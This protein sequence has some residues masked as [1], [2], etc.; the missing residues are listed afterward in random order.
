VH[1]WVVEQTVALLLDQPSEYSRVRPM[2]SYPP[3][4]NNQDLILPMWLTSGLGKECAVA[5]VA[6][7]T[8][9]G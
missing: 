3:P 9:A 6:P 2:L 7:T 5:L 1:R 4:A 8:P